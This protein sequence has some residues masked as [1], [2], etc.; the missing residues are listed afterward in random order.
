MKQKYSGWWWLRWGLGSDIVDLAGPSEEIERFVNDLREKTGAKLEW[1]AHEGI[2]IVQHFGGRKSRLRVE[3][4]LLYLS[5]PPSIAIRSLYLRYAK[6]DRA[7]LA[8]DTAR[9]ARKENPE[10]SVI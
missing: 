7:I 5:I 10:L 3:L 2:A 9:E 8:F 1:Y 4:A 6:S